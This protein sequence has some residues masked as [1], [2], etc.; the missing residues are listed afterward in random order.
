MSR[1][2][3]D[4]R[5]H[6]ARIGTELSA[7][8]LLEVVVMKA[9]L[10]IMLSHRIRN[11]QRTWL[12][13]ELCEVQEHQ[14]VILRL[15]GPRK[16]RRIIRNRF[17]LVGYLLFAKALFGVL[18][19]ALVDSAKSKLIYILMSLRWCPH[20]VHHHSLLSRQRWLL[21]LIIDIMLI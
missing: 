19:L 6:F 21:V 9:P 2:I 20:L 1:R 11:Q 14:N 3:G 7:A 4:L 17:P 13:F 5:T 8:I 10:R 18:R 12:S 16:I 15:F